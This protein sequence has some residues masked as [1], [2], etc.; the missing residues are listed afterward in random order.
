MQAS[1]PGTGAGSVNGTLG[2]TQTS[3]LIQRPALLLA[4]NTVY[5]AF[6]GCGPDPS[7]YH[8]WVL[9][10]QAAHI[11][12][13]NVA[14][15][16]TPSGDEGGI[17][18][19]G[20]GPVGDKAGSVYVEAGNGT[21]DR[22]TNF[23]ESFLKLDAKGAL[24]DWFT[25]VDV[26]HLSD[27]D[28]DLST[29]GPLL[30]PDTNLLIGSGK[31]GL[32]YVLNASSLG[33]AGN[34]VQT[35]SSSTPCDTFNDFR[36]QRLHSLAYWQHVGPSMLYTWGVNDTL[37]AYQYGSGGFSTPAAAQGAGASIC[38]RQPPE[39]KLLRGS[40]PRRGRP[41]IG[42]RIR[43]HRHDGG[44]LREMVRVH[45]VEGVG[46]GVVVVEIET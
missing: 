23:G 1:V 38:K 29:T 33:K 20:R 37:H 27:L 12:K 42:Q 39:T 19:A 40:L 43:G 25:P 14:Y 22:Q 15:V 8:G 28:L 3:N 46:G 17:W 4:K 18:Q 36:C 9:G 24:E 30:T 26:D 31:Q 21:A 35:F 7:P 6:S 5:A 11:Q 16:T 13:Q 10:Y 34:P 45:L 2:F 44:I 32:V 41:R